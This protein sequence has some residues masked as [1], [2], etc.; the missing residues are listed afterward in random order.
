MTASAGVSFSINHIAA[1]VIPNQPR[2]GLETSIMTLRQ[3]HKL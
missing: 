2:Q 3:I 1:V